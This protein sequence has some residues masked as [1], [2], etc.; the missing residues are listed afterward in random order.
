MKKVIFFLIVVFFSLSPAFTN[1]FAGASTI[2][3]LRTQLQNVLDR[4]D[5][6]KVELA[7][8]ESG[9]TISTNGESCIKINKN[10]SR[11]MNNTE[12]KKLQIFLSQDRNI[13]P[14]GI[15]TGYF[16]RLTELAVQRWQSINGVVSYG[17]AAGTGYGAVGPKTRRAI[18]SSCSGSE[19]IAG[20]KDNVVDFKFS[21]TS[22]K[23]PL[24]TVVTLS[25]LESSCMSYK[26][27]WG[28]GSEPTTR[29]TSQTTNCGVGIG[30]LSERHTY[31]DTGEYT[32]VLFAGKGSTDTLPKITSTTIKVSE[33]DTSI[34]VL[35]PNGGETLKLGEMSNIKL[36]ISNAPRD[37]AV[38][39]YVVGA[40][41]TYRFAAKHTSIARD[42]TW[43]VGNNVCDGNGCDV[44][45]QP[46]EQYK[47]RAA[48]Y[49]PANAC[50]GSC[51]AESIIPKFLDTDESDVSFSIGQL[52]ESGS[53]P[54][55]LS[56]SS[57]KAPF[58]ATINVELVPSGSGISNFDLDFGDGSP[59]Y[60]IHIPAGETR[61]TRKVLSHTYTNTGTYNVRLRPVG[62]RQYISQKQITVTEPRFEVLPNS[63]S[64]SPVIAMASFDVDNSCSYTEDITRTYT[65][66]WRDGA[67]AS[68]YEV[69][70]N[71]CTGTNDN[72]QML[73]T[74]TFLHNYNNPGSYSPRLTVSIGS[75]HYK[76][77]QNITI[78][79]PNL[80][81]SPAW[82]FKPLIST[83][84]F[85]ADESCVMGNA[86]N[87]TYNI[88]W[89]DGSADSG[90]T[91]A[92]PS[93]GS[94][95]TSRTIDRTYTHTYQNTGR[96]TVTLT[97]S[98]S[99][100]ETSYSMSKEVVVDQSALRNG[101]RTLAH[102]LNNLNIKDNMASALK[103][104]FK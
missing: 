53:S 4:I 54:L 81:V 66:D 23:S 58:N 59:T 101:L 45:L 28:D 29:N 36:L 97:I 51:G 40:N 65:V 38:V 5:A 13:Y 27:D 87:V 91:K 63:Q 79:K 32:A 52:G 67:A 89:G 60:R 16:G 90:Y 41:D 11:G 68:Q 39:F 43:M 25:M 49:T 88:D 92:L 77:I 103:S 3:E 17:T 31:S 78:E 21:S 84:K 96:Y 7:A 76:K 35:S 9:I 99:N 83:A 93:C 24:D 48:I 62:A 14:E 71:K 10:L 2:S 82:G 55:S 50:I 69:I 22:G 61:T 80:T 95:F 104:I 57:G 19:G 15:T 74:K 37:S 1:S 56:Q 42:T 30:E 33:G 75:A 44:Q 34:R 18:E 47:I 86:T 102:N 70:T 85:T 94:S 20:G 8:V 26:I 98:K 6:L 12:V 72:S 73:S 64:Y 46:N 100:M